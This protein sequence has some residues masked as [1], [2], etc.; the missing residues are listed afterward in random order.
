MGRVGEGGGRERAVKCS[1]VTESSVRG[2]ISIIVVSLHFPQSLQ[3]GG[4][5]D[6]FTK[7]E[8]EG[9]EVSNGLL[10]CFLFL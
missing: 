7:K 8:K 4:N 3:L 9:G 1:G 5:V 10:T 2:V 6:L